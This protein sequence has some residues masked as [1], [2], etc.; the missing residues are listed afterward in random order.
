M[1]RLLAQRKSAH[2]DHSNGGYDNGID[3]EVVQSSPCLYNSA[4]KGSI[5]RVPGGVV[6]SGVLASEGV[7]VV[8]YCR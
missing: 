8:W 3:V 5:E 1:G 4:C 2:G 6:H 7:R